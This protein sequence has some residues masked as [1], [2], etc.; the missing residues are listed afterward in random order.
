[1]R[2]IVRKD[3]GKG[4]K[5]YTKKLAKRAGLEAPTDNEMRQFDRNRP[6]KTVSN[7]ACENPNDPDATITR[8]KGWLDTTTVVDTATD[9]ALNAEQGG[10]ER[11]VQAIECGLGLPVM[12]KRGV[13]PWDTFTTLGT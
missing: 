9:V 1:M 6:G 7:Q 3:S 5:D 11:D 10:S 8:M 4:W 2:S 13:P 12:K